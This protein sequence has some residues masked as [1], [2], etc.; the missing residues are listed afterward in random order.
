MLKYVKRAFEHIW[1]RFRKNSDVTYIPKAAPSAEEAILPI[2]PEEYTIYPY[3]LKH[4]MDLGRDFILLDVR[5]DWEFQVVHLD[6]AVSIPLGE[7]PKRFGELSPGDEIIV[8][9]HKGMRSLDAAYLLQQLG[10]KST[11][12]LVGG[13]DKWACEIDQDMQRY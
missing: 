11:L 5:D 12:S 10:F 8:Y 6:G 1:N 9:C 7:L 3:E 13:I 4:K 2:D